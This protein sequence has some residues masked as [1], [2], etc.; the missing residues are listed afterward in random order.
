MFKHHSIPLDGSSLVE[1]VHPRGCAS[2]QRLGTRAT[3]LQ[4]VE[5]I[6]PDGRT[7][8][9]AR[10]AVHG[11]VQED[12]L[13]IDLLARNAQFLRGWGGGL[14]RALGVEREG[15]VLSVSGDRP[16]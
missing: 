9:R 13:R 8:I 10:G 1:C 15:G 4:V 11:L 5:R 7:R 16:G 2:A 12:A 14:D 3:V 6:E